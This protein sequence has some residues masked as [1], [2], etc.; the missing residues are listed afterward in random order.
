ML[1]LSTADPSERVFGIV[2]LSALGVAVLV[3]V[4]W[5]LAGRLVGEDARGNF[6]YGL[7]IGAIL[8]DAALLSCLGSIAA[9]QRAARVFWIVLTV[10]ALA[11]SI[12]LANI[13]DPDA[14]KAA[15]TVLLAVMGILAF[16]LSVVGFVLVYLYSSLF[17]VSRPT[18]AVDLVAFWG[19]LAAAGYMQWFL[20]IPMLLRRMKRPRQTRVGP[21]PSN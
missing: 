12:Y 16:P 9:V 20:I 1:D 11:L 14:Y 4:G 3:I 6:A 15:D 8:V 19:I 2:A 5:P 7:T 10:V 17:L 18:T 21:K 13:N